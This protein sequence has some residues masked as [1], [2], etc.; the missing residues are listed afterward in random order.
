MEDIKKWASD[1]ISNMSYTNKDFVSIYSE[2]L[3]LVKKLSDKWDPSL[4]NESDPGVL[5]LKLNVLLADKN[6]YNIDKN[7]LENFPLSV[8]QEGNARQIYDLVGYHMHWYKSATTSFNFNLIKSTNI[9]ANYPAIIPEFTTL[10]NSDGDVNYTTLNTLKMSD[11]K[12]T[13]SVRAIEGTV[14]DYQI[15]DS[16]IITINN[17]DSDNRLYFTENMIAENGI[18]VKDYD[19]NNTEFNIPS[20]DE[21]NPNLWKQVNNIASYTNLDSSTNNKIYEF[22]I[23]P[24]TNK[25]YLQFPDDIASN[26][27]N[28][29]VIKYIISQGKDGNTKS[30]TI[31]KFT[32]DISIKGNDDSDIILGDIIKISQPEST[33]NGSDPETLNK[34][35]FNYKKTI[36]TFD[37]LVTKRD[38]ENYSYNKTDLLGNPYVSN[39][40]V[41]DRTD[42]INNSNYIQ[43][44]VPNNPSKDLIVKKDTL[45]AYNIVLY[46]LRNVPNINDVN[47]YDE[48]F[49]QSNNLEELINTYDEVKSSQHDIKWDYTKPPFGDKYLFMNV[50]RFK[51]NIITYN[52]LTNQDIKEIRENVTK[53]LYS[54]FNSRE[55]EFGKE[56][57]YEDLVNVIIGADNRIKN[58]YLN[59][60]TYVTYKMNPIIK[61]HDEN[62]FSLL[63][64]KQ[65]D[66]WNEI[67]ARMFLSGNVQLFNFDD[68]FQYDLNET[69]IQVFPHKDDDNIKIFYKDAYIKSITSETSKAISTTEGT[70]TPINQ[71]EAVQILEPKLVT[72]TEYS[73][74]RVIGTS[75]TINEYKANELLKLTND[76][77]ITIKITGK[78]DQVIK[79]G[80]MKCSL[81]IP[82]GVNGGGETYISSGNNLIIQGLNSTTLQT[83]TK[84]YFLLNNQIYEE[85]YYYSNL[86]IPRNSNIILQE[87]EY[88]IYTDVSS[89]DLVILG[90]GTLLQNLGT[91]DINIKAPKLS[92]SQLS[93]LNKDS[94]IDWQ[95]TPQSIKIIEMNITTLGDGS[96]FWVEDK[97]DLED[98]DNNLQELKKTLIYKVGGNKTAIQPCQVEGY[99]NYI[100]SRLYINSTPSKAQLLKNGQKL[101]F[102]LSDFKGNSIPLL[103]D[104]F[105]EGSDDGVYIS[106][107]EP[108]VNSGGDDIDVS[109]L[110]EYGNINYS[111]LGFAYELENGFPDRKN[112]LLEISGDFYDKGINNLYK[113]GVVNKT[114]KTL[115][116]SLDIDTETEGDY[117]NYLIPIYVSLFS[118][119]STKTVAFSSNNKL[120]KLFNPILE[121][122]LDAEITNTTL[123]NTGLMLR[124]SSATE[125]VIKVDNCDSKDKIIIGYPVK[126]NGLNTKEI[127]ISSNDPDRSYFA[128]PYSLIDNITNIYTLIKNIT[129]KDNN[130]LGIDYTSKINWIYRVPEEDKVLQPTSPKAFFNSNHIYNKYTISK[131]NFDNISLQINQTNNY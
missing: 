64:S 43:T 61:D 52:R 46:S 88:F 94:V 126:L 27:E 40:V 60:P 110:D 14:K 112:G 36:G 78:P 118:E 124:V 72:K 123:N 6:N 67:I 2:L 31:N 86:L 18:F 127:D 53:S 95:L 32:N 5:L 128:C 34:A 19:A 96:S 54:N 77:Y 56:L 23:S 29:L 37:T 80:V 71:N 49:Y 101:I 51:G 13:Y 74:V 76:T 105:I 91:E 33:T 69:N 129:S 15:N 113:N 100:R 28:G 9:D 93:D 90:S 125:L 82:F 83:Q 116:Y 48:T 65:I 120:L 4:S 75:S 103:E 130:D 98:L 59:T 44:Y 39:I 107:N 21:S 106:F 119:G 87:N 58:V 47:S 114:N 26:I 81:N 73:F 68:N 115:T 108:V 104:Q 122:E 45:N 35:Y 20:D 50:Y 70:A 92:T 111:L 79:E 7:I 17:L 42:D 30:N 84:C 57:S 109:V 11:P 25:C 3:D 24:K 131:L 97:S 89:N 8:T 63:D 99:S 121:T 16:T 38:Y 10:T 102:T 1:N 117:Q 62:K 22:G 12:V 85:P 66:L 41:A 55:L